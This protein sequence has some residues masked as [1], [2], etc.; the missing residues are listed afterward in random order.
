[1]TRGLSKLDDGLTVATPAFVG[2]SESGGFSFFRLHPHCR[3]PDLVRFRRGV[4]ITADSF[5]LRSVRVGA[6]RTGFL[7]SLAS[8][9]AS[10]FSF[11]RRLDFA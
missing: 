9:G 4:I 3:G 1:M 5:Q 7:F 2:T 10:H 6:G 8:V 11:Q